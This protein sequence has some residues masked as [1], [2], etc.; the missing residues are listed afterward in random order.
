MS[1]DL[2]V[3]EVLVTSSASK[4]AFLKLVVQV[5]VYFALGV[6]LAT[7]GTAVV[8]PRFH[9][10]VDAGEAVEFVTSAARNRVGNNIHADAARENLIDCPD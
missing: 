1:K 4:L 2:G 3:L 7:V 9:G 6:P 5:Y 10:L 8:S